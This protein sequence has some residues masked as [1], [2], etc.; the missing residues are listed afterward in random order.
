MKLPPG[1]QLPHL[2]FLTPPHGSP[3]VRVGQLYQ[4]GLLR[5]KPALKDALSLITGYVVCHSALLTKSVCCGVNVR[6]ISA[7][8]L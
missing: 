6:T 1:P 4:L 5:A 8:L 7:N 2:A 3:F